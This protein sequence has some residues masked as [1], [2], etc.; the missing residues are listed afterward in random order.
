VTARADGNPKKE[1]FFKFPGR[2]I[3]GWYRGIPKVTDEAPPTAA[4]GLA[5][6]HRIDGAGKAELD[7]CLASAVEVEGG[8]V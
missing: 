3:F 7:E 8:G 1:E 5:E 4:K 6:I 2:G